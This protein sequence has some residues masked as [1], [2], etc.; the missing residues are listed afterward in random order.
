VII[1]DFLEKTYSKALNFSFKALNPIKKK[2]IHT[3][4]RVHKFIN[5]QGVKILK[6]NNYLGEYN[7][8]MSYITHI[9]KGSVWA[10]QDFKSNGHF[11]NPYKKK[12]LYGGKNAMNL[13][14]NYYNKSLKLWAMGSFNKSLFYLGACIHIIQ[15]MTIPQHANI[16]LL[17]NHRQYENFVKKTYTYMNE[18]KCNKNPILLNSIDKYVRFNGRIALRTYKKYKNIKYD[19]ERFYKISKISL[20][21][22]QRTTAGCMILFY[23]EIFN[24]KTK[25][26]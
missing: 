5:V 8:F 2:I 21:I 3:H 25:K 19:N 20:P 4:C 10:D 12:G 24:K 22:A 11:Y 9:N 26:S 15:D 18:F 7:F 13:A 17:D 6:S 14:K 23:N 16:K 1:L